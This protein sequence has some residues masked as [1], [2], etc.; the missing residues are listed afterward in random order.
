MPSA[1]LKP[2]KKQRQV[3]SLTANWNRDVAP[4]IILL[5]LLG[6]TGAASPAYAQTAG[7]LDPDVV[8][9]AESLS[10]ARPG[11]QATQTAFAEAQLR[12]D[13]VLN[14]RIEARFELKRL[15]RERGLHYP[16]A[17]IFVRIFKRER[18]L[19]IWVRPTTDEP[20]ALLKTYRICALAGA[21]GPKRRQGD[22][23]VP[24]GFYYIDQFNP[25]SDYLLSLHLDYPNRSDAILG[26]GGA[27]GGDIYMHGGCNSA[28]CLALTDDGIK[29]V[30]W[31][32]VEARGLGQTRIPVH[33]FPT[34][35]TDSEMP[36]LAR[37][38]RNTPALMRFWE[39]LK[40]GYE[41]FEQARRVPR[42]TVAANGSYRLAGED[43]L[44]SPAAASR[45]RATAS[46]AGGGS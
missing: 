18:E 31:L 11:P 13:R 23:Q 45:N 26:R 10:H 9:E 28:G 20:F 6:V 37:A 38:F 34:R 33:I 19:E 5:A 32:S 30:Y 40:P 27:L 24:E 8:P 3:R 12:Y 41:Y 16:A 17:E 25:V 4:T 29:E 42:M 7:G 1:R 36:R 46:G 22:E 44:S 21:L 43:Q 39:T 15:F 2:T 14:A 35:L